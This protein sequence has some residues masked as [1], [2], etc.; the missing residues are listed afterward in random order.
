[1]Y[2]ELD[3]VGGDDFVDES[4]DDMAPSVHD[5]NFVEQMASP[6]LEEPLNKANNLN[7]VNSHTD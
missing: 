2:H 6:I 1:M 3:N 5:A 4:L 7:E